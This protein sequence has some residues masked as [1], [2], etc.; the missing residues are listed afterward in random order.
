[1]LA[2][3]ILE[4]NEIL[5]SRMV[6]AL[7]DW[8]K[9]LS[10]HQFS[11]NA[12]FCRHAETNDVDVLLA[13]IRVLDGSGLDSIAYIAAKKPNS[14][15][16]VISALSDGESILQAIA[17]GAIGYLH[18]DDTSFEIIATI[19]MALKGESPISP[20]IARKLI[21]ELKHPLGHNVE[22]PQPQRNQVKTI[23]TDREVEVL[24]L[25]A[26]GLSYAECATVL[27]IS[28]QTIPV[29]VRNIYRKLQAKNRSEAVFE[30]RH[31]GVIE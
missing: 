27:N 4:D 23:L 3:S 20:A 21:R 24:R 17:N 9:A 14:V 7:Q 22:A 28:T 26:K 19:E 16:I 1:M 25:I 13:D 6:R 8:D 5:R 11:E 10:I 15:S 31:L 30:A 18:K 2:I 29:H 12:A